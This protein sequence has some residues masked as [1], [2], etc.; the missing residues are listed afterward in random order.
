MTSQ[1]FWVE[2]YWQSRPESARAC[3]ARLAVMLDGLAKAHP[4]FAR[5]YRKARTRA[6]ANKSAW[7]MPPD[8]DELTA[9]FEKGRQYKDVPRVPWPEIGYAVLA[10]NGCER[11][12]AASLT[13]RSGGYRN[14]TPFPNTA[15]LRLNLSVTGNADL[16]SRTVLEAVLLS[17]A[18]AWEPDYGVVVCGDYWRRLFGERHYPMFRSGWMTYLAARYASR[19]TPP[20]E[21]TAERVPGGGLLLLATEERFRMDNPAHLA[22]ADAIQAALTPIQDMVPPGMSM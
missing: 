21:A 5:W 20:P 11:P 3:A 2:G 13:I 12:Y 14:S 17:L 7:G 16:I 4:A 19:V 8:I 9:V 10:W 6:A 15:A 18:E 22:A 1:V